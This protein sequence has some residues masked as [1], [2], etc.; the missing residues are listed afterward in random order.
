MTRVVTLNGEIINVGDWDLQLVV[1]DN[2]GNPYD[3]EGDPPEDWDYQITTTMEAMNPK[4]DGAIVEDIDIM[5]DAEG[6]IRRADEAHKYELIAKLAEAK[7]EL[8]ELMVDIQLGMASPEEI[9][10]AK[11]LRTFIKENPVT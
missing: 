3:G 11:E 4:P 8:D 1:V 10:R 7:R 6:R 2:I 9:E 5:Y